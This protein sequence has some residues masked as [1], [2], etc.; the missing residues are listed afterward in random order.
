M[1]LG[2]N[3]ATLLMSGHGLLAVCSV[4]YLVW[5]IIFFRPQASKVTGALYYFGAGCLV[6]AALAGIAGAVLVGMGIS[7]AGKANL[8]PSGWWFAI[9]A[10]IVYIALVLLTTRVFHRPVTT[11]LVLF[12]AWSALELAMIATLA[13]VNALS[14][15]SSTLLGTLVI[16]LFVGMLICYLLYFHL[17]PLPSFIDGA[18]PLVAVGVFSIGMIALIA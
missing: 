8:S 18:I 7:G 12:V 14:V 13:S 1:T 5:W 11:E 10:V 9:G 16:V 2:G 15:T 17:A 4:L 3:S 6:V